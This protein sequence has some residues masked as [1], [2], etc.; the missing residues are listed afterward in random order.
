MDAIDLTRKK[1]VN[2]WA[3]SGLAA[4]LGVVLCVSVAAAEESPPTAPT[5]AAPQATP[6]HV[7]P[8]ILAAKRRAE[9]REAQ[10]PRVGLQSLMQKNA[11]RRHGVPAKRGS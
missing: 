1:P 6:H 4:L 8:H 11:A 7:S 5:E 9:Q 10:Q 2:D 3:K